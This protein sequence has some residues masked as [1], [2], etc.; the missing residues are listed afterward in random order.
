MAPL[1]AKLALRIPVVEAHAEL[2]E[3]VADVGQHRVARE[4]HDGIEFLHAQCAARVL[5]EPV[6]VLVLVAGGCIGRRAVR[7]VRRGPLERIAALLV[8]R[9]RDGQDVFGAITVRREGDAFAAQLEISQIDADREDVDLPARIVD[10]VLAIER[11]PGGLEQVAQRRAVGRA[12]AVAHVHGARGIRRDE[13]DH[14]LAAGAHVAAPVSRA[15]CRHALERREPRVLRQAEIDEAGAGDLCARDQRAFRQRG[16]Q[17]LR[18]FAWVLARR[19]GDAHGDVA[20]EVAVLRITR[21]LDHHLGGIRPLRTKQREQVIAAPREAGVQA[22]ISRGEPVW[23]SI[24]AGAILTSLE[25]VNPACKP[26]AG[27]GVNP[28]AG[29]VFPKETPR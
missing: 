1:L 28:S 19:L 18:Q 14:H 5:D 2:F 13:L 11:V 22:R 16:H 25:P 6:D 9:L 20:L 26:I 12:A 27:E 3:I 21:A 10:V 24:K 4:Q 17:R 15:Q 29:L 7:D 23:N 8:Q